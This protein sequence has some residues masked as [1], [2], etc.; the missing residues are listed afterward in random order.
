MSQEFLIHG[1]QRKH[2]VLLQAAACTY[3]LPS[4]PASLKANQQ[5]SEIRRDKE[6]KSHFLSVRSEVL[7]K[8]QEIINYI[9]LPRLPNSSRHQRRV[10]LR[11]M[12]LN[13]SFDFRVIFAGCDAAVFGGIREA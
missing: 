11:R 5:N 2:L 3:R 9:S 4:Q 12:N 8:T 10:G 6:T 13:K 1:Y 7:V